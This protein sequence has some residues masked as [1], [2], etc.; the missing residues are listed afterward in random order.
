[1]LVQ[2]NRKL[3]G[4]AI[5]G[6]GLPSG[7]RDV[8]V[9]Q[10]EDCFE[11]CYDRRDDGFRKSKVGRRRENLRASKRRDFVTRMLTLIAFLAVRLCRV[12]TGGDFYSA[13]Y[14]KKWLLVMARS[15]K[16]RFWFYTRSWRVPAI[17]RVIEEMS[18]LPNVRVWYSLDRGTGLPD[19]V[20]PRVRL[21][22]L[23]VEEDDLP[24]PDAQLAFRVRRLRKKAQTRV[25]KGRVCPDEDGV[26]RATHVSCGAGCD[27]CYRPLPQD[28]PAG[29]LP[30]A[31]VTEGP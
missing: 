29:R 9:G 13:A 30:L 8:C 21:A 3:R 19:F 18:T 23:Q 26:K 20:P 14:A 17:A 6:F 2:G 5:W 28:E 31:V 22:Y 11:N 7:G 4:R 12:H 15:P 16:V 1:M 27:L 10:S 24:P 25:G